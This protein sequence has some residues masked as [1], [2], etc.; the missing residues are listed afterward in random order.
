MTKTFGSLDVSFIQS[1]KNPQ[2]NSPKMYGVST[3]WSEEK[4]IRTFLDFYVE[5]KV[6]NNWHSYQ[7]PRIYFVRVLCST[8][9]I[10]RIK[11]HFWFSE[12]K[13][14]WFCN[15][16]CIFL[17]SIFHFVQRHRCVVVSQSACHSQWQSAAISV[18][19]G[20]RKL[21][22]LIKD[23]IF[24]KRLKATRECTNCS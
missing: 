6:H 2:L 24:N 1:K 18:L 19:I 17:L 14:K 21:G 9:R 22:T 10:E 13:S 5:C 23:H 20:C 4:R 3:K 12:E 15:N 11:N 16:N 7:D 8:F